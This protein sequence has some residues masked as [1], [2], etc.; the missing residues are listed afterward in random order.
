MTLHWTDFPDAPAVG[1]V[2]FSLADLVEGAVLSREVDGYPVLALLQ[3]GVPRVY[4]NAC[5]HQFLPLD[6]HGDR[7]LSE[8]GRHLMCSNHSALFRA[9]DG[10]GTAGEGVGCALSAV[11]VVIDAGNVLIGG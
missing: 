4:V 11:P 7:L 3:A 8:D 1:A 5:P 9:S 6:H 10:V 2:L